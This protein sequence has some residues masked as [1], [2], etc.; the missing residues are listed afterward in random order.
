M[1]RLI[2]KT[3]FSGLVTAWRRATVPT[4]R[5]PLLEKATTDGV[6]RP[7]SEFGMTV[8]SPPSRTLTQLNV[9][10][11]SIPITL[12]I[13]LPPWRS[14]ILVESRG[15]IKSECMLCQ[16]IARCHRP[17]T[18]VVAPQTPATR[19]RSGLPRCRRPSQVRGLESRS[20][21]S[22]AT[23][24]L[25]GGPRRPAATAAIMRAHERRAAQRRRRDR[26]RRRGA[27]RARSSCRAGC[28]SPCCRCCCIIAWLLL[29]RIGEAVFI[30]IVATLLALALNPFVRG[31]SA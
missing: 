29:A 18:R 11:R 20:N 10:P 25:E 24:S 19:L 28:S 14:S 2:E 21:V 4:R 13:R 5:S 8:G 1:K 9:V 23:T 6:V 3:V 12:A 30:F 22:A 7:P 26:G 27:G 17:Q 15:I 16:L 31:C